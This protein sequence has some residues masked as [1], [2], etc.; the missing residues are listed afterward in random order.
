V[1]YPW[2]CKIRN[3][4]Y[5]AGETHYV[6]PKVCKHG[7]S[8][9]RRVKDG[10]CQACNRVSVK[11]SRAKTGYK[12]DQ[13]KIKEWRQKNPHMQR[14]YDSRRSREQRDKRLAWNKMRRHIMPA[15]VTDQ[16]KREMDEIYQLAKQASELSGIPHEV[17]HIIPVRGRRVCG[18][19]V[20][21]NLQIITQAENRKKGNSHV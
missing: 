1:E 3:A 17:D 19:H 20:P 5:E 4:A 9:L 14:I 10:L 6:S 16:M 18:L 12:P 8:E 11:K 7:H 13:E 2:R 15:Y 21:A